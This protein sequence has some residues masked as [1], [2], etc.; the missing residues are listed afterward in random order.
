MKSIMPFVFIFIV[1]I[2]LHYYVYSHIWRALEIFPTTKIPVLVILILLSLSYIASQ[3]FGQNLPFQ[4]TSVIHYIGASWVFYLVMSL[5]AV[6]LI[7]IVH[8]SDYLFHWQ[9]QVIA[10]NYKF[11]KFV[12]CVSMFAIITILYCIG[13]YNF[14]NTE[15]RE[16]TISLNSQPTKQL[17]IVQVSDLHLGYTV[18]KQTLAKFVNA[19]NAEEPDIVCL[20]GDIKDMSMYPIK[21]Q[22]MD[23]ELRQI[24]AK[25]GVFVI[26]GNHEYIGGEKDEAM[27][28][29]RQCG[30][31]VLEDSSILVN[32][33]FYVAGRKDRTDKNRKELADVVSM[34]DKSKTIILLD[35][36]PFD[37]QNAVDA[38][39]SLQ[40]SGH[41]HNGQF[42]PINLITAKIYEVSHGY[43][44]KTMTHFFVSSGIGGWGPPVRTASQS[45][46]IKI[47]LKY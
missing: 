23:E 47:H 8:L 31:N 41:T 4:L 27:E 19:I 38:G 20:C 39:V 29:Y 3:L 15:V 44:Q 37:L 30:F 13:Q 36:Q 11:V 45:E 33:E 14:F 21:E 40:L 1:Y 46:L 18:D 34:L 42:F 26:S 9:P 10:D 28:Y 32:G 16:L 43:L 25:Y 22:K 24:K 7:D 35:H 5:L 12:V 2:L 17:N 6:I